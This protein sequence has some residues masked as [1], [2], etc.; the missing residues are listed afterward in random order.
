M[1]ARPYWD[2]YQRLSHAQKVAVI[3]RYLAHRTIDAEPNPITGT[4]CWISTNRFENGYP[5]IWLAGR[6]RY[7]HRLGLVLIGVFDDPTLVAHHICNRGPDGCLNPSHI[8]LVTSRENTMRSSKAPAA[9]NAAKLF[10]DRMHPLMAGHQN[11][12]VTP[13]GARTCR[14][15]RSAAERRTRATRL[16][17]EHVA[18]YEA[19]IAAGE[20]PDPVEVHVRGRT[21]TAP[22]SIAMI[23]PQGATT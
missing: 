23:G 19:A 17:A 15:C 10:C 22:V 20:T 21:L 9:I 14:A 3:L 7:A 8:E 1:P 2:A 16:F 6:R 12:Y 11:T 5:S 4:P 13:S 18:A